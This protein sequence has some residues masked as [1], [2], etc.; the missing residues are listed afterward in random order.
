MGF[1]I[2]HLVNK[3]AEDCFQFKR[4][5]MAKCAVRCLVAV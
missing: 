1:I 3:G 5:L 4:G 2:G